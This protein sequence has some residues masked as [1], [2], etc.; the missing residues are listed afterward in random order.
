VEL[1]EDELREDNVIDEIEGYNEESD[2]K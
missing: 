1:E 2:D